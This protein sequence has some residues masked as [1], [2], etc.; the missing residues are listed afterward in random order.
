MQ[1]TL[2]TDYGCN[3]T[4][5]LVEEGSNKAEFEGGKY[6]CSFQNGPPA[7]GGRSSAFLEQKTLKKPA[8]LLKLSKRGRSSEILE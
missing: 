1:T 3:V 2:G 8:K 5:I 4:H 7:P 6:Q